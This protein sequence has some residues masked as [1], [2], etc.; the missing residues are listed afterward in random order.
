[1]KTA[2]TLSAYR[3]FGSGALVHAGFAWAL[4]AMDCA[5]VGGKPQQPAGISPRQL[6]QRE[7]T[8][9]SGEGCA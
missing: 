2:Y 8:I 9:L 5:M 4:F 6:D 1:M 3:C 7:N